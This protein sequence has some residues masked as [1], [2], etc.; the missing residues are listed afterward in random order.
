MITDVMN[1]DVPTPTGGAP[2]NVS[3]TKDV[4]KINSVLNNVTTTLVD[5]VSGDVY[6]FI[7]VQ[8][9]DAFLVG[10]SVDIST[11]GA[12]AP[13]LTQSKASNQKMGVTLALVD[14]TYKFISGTQNYDSV[15]KV[16][17]F[18][19]SVVTSS[20]AA[21]PTPLPNDTNY[22]YE[23]SFNSSKKTPSKIDSARNAGGIYTVPNIFVDKSPIGDDVYTLTATISYMLSDYAL[24]SIENPSNEPSLY[25]HPD[26]SNAN[27]KSSVLVATY[28]STTKKGRTTEDVPL[29]KALDLGLTMNI[30][31]VRKLVAYWNAD[32][33]ASFRIQSVQLEVMKGFAGTPSSGANSFI[34]LVLSSAT[35]F[36][37]QVTP[38]I[39]GTDV[40]DVYVFNEIGTVSGNPAV[41]SATA[42]SGSFT[43]RARATVADKQNG[44]NLITSG[45]AYDS[46]EVDPVIM[47][48]PTAVSIASVAASVGK[49]FNVSFTAPAR[50]AI[51]S[52]SV[53]STW[54]TSYTIAL[55]S[56]LVSLFDNDSKLID[57]KVYTFSDAENA[58]FATA[59][60]AVAA[61]SFTEL[62][63]L[64]AGSNVYAE[65]QLTYAKKDSTLVQAGAKSDRN[66]SYVSVSPSISVSEVTLTQDPP[67]TGTGNRKVN[68]VGMTTLKVSGKVT[69]NGLLPAGATV[70]AVISAADIQGGANT[71]LHTM[72]Y[73]ASDETWSTANLYPNVAVNYKSAIVL[74][75]ANHPGSSN[76]T[77]FGVLP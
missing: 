28:S 72:T 9:D 19:P 53:P 60:V 39:N 27:K 34:P 15:T 24:Q 76:V 36:P 6:A 65:V 66:A 35:P 33:D 32:Y 64:V 63:N 49:S 10:K 69:L 17:S 40:A 77:T 52:L 29:L 16:L 48:G 1:V 5:F 12:N 38:N 26:L 59:P 75:I 8:H 37:T 7:A 30:L 71:V 54:G 58:T 42:L 70:T 20:G 67:A 56:A 3:F 44:D 43:V 14:K 11:I 4:T 50:T 47:N 31:G 57:S 2:Q 61:V 13:P 22:I 45:W 68:D 41:F 55:K 62:Q 51:S 25:V 73:D 46:Y 74:V 23:Y 18:S 21:L